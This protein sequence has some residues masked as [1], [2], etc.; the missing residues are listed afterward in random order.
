MS[1]RS[2]G[3]LQPAFLGGL[4]TG[5]FSAL[6]VI[7]AGNFCCCLWVI[8]GGL[9]AAYLL[10]QNRPEAIT[11]GDG[12]IVGLLAGII[13]AVV[14]F[15]LSIPI[16]L[17]VGPVEQQMLEQLREIAGSSMPE[18]R[19]IGFGD[20]TSGMLGVIAL[21]LVSFFFSLVVGSI[22]STVAGVV[23]AA[24]FGRTPQDSRA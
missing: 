13:G 7:S 15:V 8:C 24:L 21:S 5:V 3:Y 9:L 11:A 2:S 20:G 10:Q 14:S 6:P 1:I 22:V 23:G 18:G 12:A 17:L 4:V 16:G 19:N